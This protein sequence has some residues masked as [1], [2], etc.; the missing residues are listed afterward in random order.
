MNKK[1]IIFITLTITAI[2]CFFIY[3]KDTDPCPVPSL[4]NV[5]SKTA[6]GRFVSYNVWQTDRIKR[7]DV[8]AADIVHLKPDII[9]LQEFPRKNEDIRSIVSRKT[10]ACYDFCMDCEIG[11]AH[12]ILMYRTDK[13]KQTGSGSFPLLK[14][15]VLSWANFTHRTSFIPI[16]V[17]GI[18]QPSGRKT[19]NE[20][21]RVVNIDSSVAQMPLDTIA[22]F[23][24]DFNARPFDLSIQYV[25]ELGFNKIELQPFTWSNVETVDYI[26]YRNG[27]NHHVTVEHAEVWNQTI[28]GSDH[29]P[30]L[31]D[32]HITQNI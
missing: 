23:M 21:S 20:P 27:K 11:P 8:I 31:A 7:Q 26:M 13:W 16:N 15:R 17:Y 1:Y 10:G 6:N 3:L 12:A 19:V 2:I 5:V 9:S 29:Y 18:H 28:S 30:I 14:N 24:G 22:I 25:Q 32:L 4:S